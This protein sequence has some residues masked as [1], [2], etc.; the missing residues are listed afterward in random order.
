MYIDIIYETENAR[1]KFLLSDIEDRLNYY[2]YEHGV[3]KAKDII[4][5]LKR[6][7]NT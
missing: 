3:E 1:F 6:S 5:F 2:P 7:S 4:S